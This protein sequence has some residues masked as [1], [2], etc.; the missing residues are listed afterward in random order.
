MKPVVLSIALLLA[1]ATSLTAGVTSPRVVGMLGAAPSPPALR[2]TLMAYADSARATNR[3]GAGEA[4]YLAGT[5]FDRGSQ[6]DSA[7]VLYRMASDLRGGNEEGGALIDALLA[8]RAEGDIPDALSRATTLEA[9]RSGDP[10]EQ[11]FMRG[12]LAWALFLDSHPDSAA[13]IF[14][15][16]Q[17]QLEAFPEWRYR[18]AKVASEIGDDRRTFTLLLPNVLLSRGTDKEVMDMLTKIGSTGHRE[19]AFRNAILGLRNRHEIREAAMLK[20]WHGSRG[21]IVASDGFRLGGVILPPF[22]PRASRHP[23]AA[24]VITAP[25]DSLPLYDSLAVRLAR[26]G[27]AVMLLDPRGSGWSVGPECPTHDSWYGGEQGMQT[28]VARDLRPALRA[29]TQ[30]TG[31][32]TSRY[33]VIG[34]GS[35][36]PIAV[37]GAEL[38]RRV[39]AVVLVS[40]APSPVDRGPMAARLARLQLPAFLVSAPEDEL[41]IPPLVDALYQAGDRA[42]SLATE[43]SMDGRRATQFRNDA[44]VS[45]RLEKW[46]NSTM[47]PRRSP[48]A[49]PRGSRRPG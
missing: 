49:T 43:S 17:P 7:I 39:R 41:W 14:N 48:P 15:A 4:L 34:V 45:S 21:S 8:R 32:D 27:L 1:F 5:S 24:I 47:A 29:L 20:L 2:A 13:V 38:D 19:Q 37:E 26:S 10:Q 12:R 6:R 46:L 36:A 11:A 9:A 28:L 44:D 18:M 16:I 35:T 31:A 33:V 30:A 42:A 22:G 40:P 3:N 23:R 25:E